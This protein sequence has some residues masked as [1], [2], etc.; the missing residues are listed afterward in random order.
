M[1]WV[2]GYYGPVSYS[3]GLAL[4]DGIAEHP[5]HQ[6]EGPHHD[7]RAGG[8]PTT[9]CIVPLG[10]G[11]GRQ[12][13]V[14]GLGWQRIG[15]KRRPMD[16]TAWADV[17]APPTPH[18][19]DL[20]GHFVAL[21]WSSDGWHAWTDRFGVR[22][23]YLISWRGG[24]LFSTR[25]D[26]LC[27]T[28]GHAALNLDAFG[29]H[30]LTFNQ[31]TTE[32]LVQDVQ[33]LGPGGKARWTLR[34][35]LHLT[36]SPW[37]PTASSG[38]PSFEAA[39]TSFLVPDLPEEAHL[40]LGLSGGLDSRLL[41]SLLPAGRLQVHAFGDTG[42]PDVR[43]SRRIA[44]DLALPFRHFH[45]PVP[46]AVTCLDLLHAHVARTQVVSPAS[47]IL[48]LRY[49]DQLREAGCWVIDGGFGEVARRQFMNRLLRRGRRALRHLDAEGVLPH[50]RVNRADVFSD[51]ALQ[52]MLDGAVRQLEQ[53]WATMPPPPEVGLETHVDLLGVRTRLPNFFGYEQ[54]R[55]DGLAPCY[56]PLA[57]PSVVHA[58]F[59]MPLRARRGGRCVRQLIRRH[60]PYLA[61][62]PLVKGAT[63][64]PFHL[65]PML[66][67]LW[68]HAQS[69]VQ[70]PSPNSIRHAFLKRLRPFALDAV[71]STEVNN[72]TLYD[73]EKLRN[74]VHGYYLDG[75][76][77]R[78]GA[79]DWWLAFEV[80][81]RTLRA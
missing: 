59:Q 23:L 70:R 57:Q 9:C 43:L 20:D 24:V 38:D 18:L 10:G 41:L 17:L 37:S 11:G 79:L 26:W 80:W 2:F 78:A 28:T 21:R 50:L 33:R 8:L 14:V 4:Q 66:A 12:G 46:D 45:A 13:V 39:V 42:H 32:A 49:Y 71:A 27:R 63:T 3:E 51:A 76:S 47:A 29:G 52:A 56:M 55:L 44:E 67:Y 31:L 58:A 19:D 16:A 53:Q 34:D 65:T 1:S 75:H 81:R 30:W 69:L 35:G 60:R 54:N 6:E 25:L 68:T 15:P 40:S 61:R 74:L 73:R 22:T 7:V 62:Y 72:E 64:Y 77:D 36:E 5:L 48:G